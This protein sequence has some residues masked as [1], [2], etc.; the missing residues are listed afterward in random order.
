MATD[1]ND[2]LAPHPERD[3]V[4]DT[5]ALR[6]LAH[7]MRLN[8]LHYL[9]DHGP[10]TGRRL[11][12][13]FALDSG[14]VS[15]HLRKLAGG[16]LIEEDVERGTRR[17][18]W[19]RVTHQALYHDPADSPADASDAGAYLQSVLIAYG[20]ALR[21]YSADV[22]HLPQE[23]FAV[24]MASERSLRLTPQQLV[25]LKR[26][27]VSVI[28]RYR[29]LPARSA[30]PDPAALPAQRAAQDLPAAARLVSVHLH[31]LPQVDR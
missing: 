22:P 29:D 30:E 21:R 11:A 4:L 8:F 20:E 23:W 15:Y 1:P 12:E 14:A 27:L 31:T 25:E 3:L 2:P 13:H 19:W 17:D 6:V 10:A 7:P 16:G 9:R 5:A 24:T 26:D 18:R 28:D